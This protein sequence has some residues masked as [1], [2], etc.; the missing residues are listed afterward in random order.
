[1]RYPG[2]PCHLGPYCWRDPVGKKH[3]KLKTHHL[4]SLIR[5]VEQD[6]ELQTYDV[7]PEDIL[8]QLYAEEQQW[9][10][11]RQTTTSTS[12]SNF[13]SINIMNA[14]SAQPYQTL[15]G[16]SPTATLVSDLSSLSTPANRLDIPGLRDVAVK[17]YS[18]WQQSKVSDVALK[19]EFQKACHL[20]LADGLDLEQIREDQDPDFFIEKGVKRG[21]ARRFVGD[22]GQWAKGYKRAETGE[23]LE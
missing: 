8:Q 2:P 10:E 6:N 1:M 12:T 22:I 21:I 4:K 20:T 3:Y 15:F 17:N 19:V 7:V 9:L 23:R 13:P 18:N 11:R 14:L 5:H 16:T